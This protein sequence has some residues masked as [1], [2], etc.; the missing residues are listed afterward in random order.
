[1][2]P[3]LLPLVS[4][5]NFKTVSILPTWSVLLLVICQ[6]PVT[7]LWT[8]RKRNSISVQNILMFFFKNYNDWS[9]VMF[10][11]IIKN[12]PVETPGASKNS[13]LLSIW[14]AFSH[15]LKAINPADFFK[16]TNLVLKNGNACFLKLCTPYLPMFATEFWDITAVIR[17]YT[18]IDLHNLPF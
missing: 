2:Y 18:L 15:H 7:I 12:F 13:L 16:S 17:S 14:R 5:N 9:I 3:C 8:H 11:G 10:W 6:N 1:M 4:F